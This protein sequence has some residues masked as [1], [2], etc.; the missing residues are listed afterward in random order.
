MTQVFE[1][2][3]FSVCALREDRSAERFHDLLDS[4]S[5]TGELILCGTMGD[6]ALERSSSVLACRIEIP[7]K[8]EGSHS[9][10]L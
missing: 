9:H 4:H 5:L 3:Q 2:F 10:R 1:E 6:E 8:P 7:D